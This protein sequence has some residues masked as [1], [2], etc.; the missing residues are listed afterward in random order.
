MVPDS[1]GNTVSYLLFMGK[2]QYVKN[3][4]IE[5]QKKNIKNQNIESLH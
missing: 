1:I 3:H 5:S 4:F 2:G